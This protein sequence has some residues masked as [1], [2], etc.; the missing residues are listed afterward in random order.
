MKLYSDTGITTSCNLSVN[1]QI[2]NGTSLTH[3]H[4]WAIHVQC[5]SCWFM[6][7]HTGEKTN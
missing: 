6:L 3:Q 2:L 5:H 7:E 4:I 1:E